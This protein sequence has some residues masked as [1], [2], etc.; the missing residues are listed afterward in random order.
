MNQFF[1]HAYNKIC[2][3][4]VELLQIN[5]A[6]TQ[7]LLHRQVYSSSEIILPI[8]EIIVHEIGIPSAEALNLISDIAYSFVPSINNFTLE[9][10]SE[11][12]SASD[13]VLDLWTSPSSHKSQLLRSIVDRVCT[14]KD[15]DP[16]M[17]FDCD[18]AF[19]S[20]H[21]NSTQPID[22]RVFRIHSLVDLVATFDSMLYSVM[23]RSSPQPSVVIVDSFT[24]LLQRLTPDDYQRGRLLVS[25]FVA[26]CAR[27]NQSCNTV[28]VLVN[29]LISRNPNGELTY[30]SCSGH[31]RTVLKQYC[32]K[33]I[34]I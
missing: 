22:S 6:I 29:N 34:H 25:H 19:Y 14:L 16:C 32:H 20:Y 33:S 17:Y 12:L 15:T 1:V 13:G 11:C 9:F 21:P 24:S 7:G 5:P 8:L 3:T 23:D 18:G 31:Y 10:R 30:P 2:M 4:P 27:F 28:V 26:T